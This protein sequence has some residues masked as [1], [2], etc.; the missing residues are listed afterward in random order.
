MANMWERRGKVGKFGVNMDFR[1]GDIVSHNGTLGEIKGRNWPV[2]RGNG[3]ET[4]WDVHMEGN[5]IITLQDKEM[6]LHD[7]KR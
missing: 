4:F 1:V 5:Q 7:G 2:N 6:E 3:R